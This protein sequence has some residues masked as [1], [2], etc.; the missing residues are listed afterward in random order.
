[1][2]PRYH[3]LLERIRLAFPQPVSDRVHDS[4]FV[5]SILRALDR[6]DALKTQIPVLGEI[7][8]IDFDAAQSARLRDDMT[9]IEDV[10][11][12]LVDY[13]R[14]M[15]LFGHPRQQQNVTPPPS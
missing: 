11:T 15:T 6:V 10:T 5:H 4:Y 1:M 9:S 3:D 14:G 8:P 12:K 13:L 7:G 2:A